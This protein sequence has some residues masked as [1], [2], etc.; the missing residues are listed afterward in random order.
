MLSKSL[1]VFGFFA[2]YAKLCSAADIMSKANPFIIEAVTGVSPSDYEVSVEGISLTDVDTGISDIKAIHNGRAFDVKANLHWEE[3]IF[4]MNSTNTLFWEMS[5]GGEVQDIG[6]INLNANR[7]L[8]TQ[9]DAGQSVIDK[10]GRYNIQVRI[11]LD[12]VVN[13]NSRD[14]ESFAAGASFVPLIMVIV[15]AASTK[16]VELSLGMG[17]FT[18]ACMVTGSIV[19]GFRDMLDVYLL[20]ALADKDHGYVFLFILFMA[21]LVGL[22][23][24]S[25]GLIGI[26]H[27]LRNFVKTSR[28]AQS[29]SFFAGIIIFFDDYANTLVAGAS[30]KPLTD[31]C[32]VSREKL[33]FIV[34]A[35]AAPIASI[36]PISSWVG[37]EISLIQAELNRILLQDPDS[38]IGNMSSF[39]VFLET[40]K[41]RYYCI[42]MLMFIPLLILTGRDFGPMLV[43]ER[44]TKVYG[45][46]DGGPG[47]AIAA[48][49][50][51]IV[52]HNAPKPDTPPKW[53]NMAFPIVMLIIYIFYLLVWTGQQAAG[54]IELSFIELIELSNAYQALL[55]GTMAAALTGLAFY[56]IQDKKDGR[57]IFCNVKGYINK[58]KRF[59]ARHQGICRR[60]Q[61][62]EVASADVEDE[63]EHAVVLM[64]YR[65]AMAAFLIGMEKIFGALVALTLAW[66]TG[67]IMQAVGLDR[68][69]GEILTNPNLDYRMLPTLTFIISILIAFST[70]TSWGTMTIMFPLV[71]VPSYTASSGDPIIFYGV[72]AGILAGAVAGD[73]AS[74]ISDTTI[75]A[76]MASECQILE[77][78]KTQ[79]PY[80]IM[81]SIW[82]ILVGTIPS[83]RQTF[84]NWLSILLGFIMMLFHVVFTS[85]FTIN[86]TGR[87]DV[88]TE[89]YLR[90]TRDKEFLLKLKADTKTA[91]ETGAPVQLVEKEEAEKMIEGDAGTF[92][93]N[94]QPMSG[95]DSSSKGGEQEQAVVSEE[96]VAVVED[97]STPEDVQQSLPEDVTSAFPDDVLE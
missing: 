26:T 62:E 5:V 67:E 71:L 79:A 34:D 65:E 16:M 6:A 32:V 78:V 36:V 55:W 50:E 21:G 84:A 53:W 8:P 48:N 88:F 85:E 66:A 87:Y 97:S 49:G 61:E 83:G 73:H 13:G 89:I 18:G 14:Y 27:A 96:D 80:A 95:S 22:L 74:P 60:G 51:A 76:S 4:D 39:S 15:F 19:A 31:A 23:E 40:I 86:K 47:R 56:F 58:M 92:D 35:T 12:T 54:D 90:C 43:A 59:R 33:A 93:K 20:D 17:I 91:F 69:F 82:S 64:G 42:F 94:D 44:L 11:R 24:K 38:E 29:A 9:I 28:T 77:H 2:A 30:M 81:V 63:G 52:S 1:A 3:E 25:G 75:L 7:A 41:Y 46:T 37:F 68:F 10:S 70:G 45:R 57:I 72:T